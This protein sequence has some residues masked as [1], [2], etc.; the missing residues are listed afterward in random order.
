MTSVSSLLNGAFGL[1]R[2]HPRAVLAWCA[3]YLVVTVGTALYWMPLQSA[4]LTPEAGPQALQDLPVM[5]LGYG[6]VGIAAIAIQMV[7]LSAAYR[8]VLRPAQASFAYLRFGAN[9]LR[10]IVLAI[11]VIVG[12]YLLI[13]GGIFAIAFGAAYFARLG[14]AAAIIATIVAAFGGL[15]FIC[16]CVWLA[17]RLCLAFPLMMLRGRF[18]IGEAWRLSRGHFWTLFATFIIVAILYFVCS[19]VI[20]SITMASYMSALVQGGLFDPG[21]KTGAAQE[22]A[23]LRQLTAITP[24]TVIG[25]LLGAIVGGVFTGLNGGATAT[26]VKDLTATDEELANTFA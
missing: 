23:M 9:E 14:P 17:V 4:M 24:L 20:G 16:L 10:Q 3:G 2:N 22:A 15:A 1:I 5:L 18:A 6:I 21:A 11:A 8:A 13:A 12:F 19:A 26:A 7:L 25:W